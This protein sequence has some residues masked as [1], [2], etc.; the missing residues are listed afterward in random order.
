MPQLPGMNNK[1]RKFGTCQNKAL[2]EVQ[3]SV[4]TIFK[5]EGEGSSRVT[6]KREEFGTNLERKVRGT[7]IGRRSQRQRGQCTTKNG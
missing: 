4:L 3:F 2:I 6:K 1:Q 5:R 7:I